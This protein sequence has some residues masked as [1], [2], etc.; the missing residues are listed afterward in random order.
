M[1]NRQP[2][3]MLSTEEKQT[4]WQRKETIK[5]MKFLRLLGEQ[6]RHELPKTIEQKILKSQKSD[7][8]E[9]KRS[10][11][12]RARSLCRAPL[13]KHKASPMKQKLGLLHLKRGHTIDE[14]NTISPL[15]GK[16]ELDHSM[17]RDSDSKMSNCPSSHT[18]S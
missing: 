10:Y 1:L 13:P 2:D 8:S 4:K 15:K 14:N 16:S 18:N 5:S 12:G 9:K 7:V 11:R 6:L 17:S 3:L